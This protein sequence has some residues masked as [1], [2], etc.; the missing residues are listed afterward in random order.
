MD[1][2]VSLADVQAVAGIDIGSV[3]C[4]YTV[5]TCSKAV[6]R[7]PAEF[8]NTAAG[9]A[10]LAAQLAHLDLAPAQLLVGVEATSRYW[11]NL[12]YFLVG[13]GYAVQVLHPAQTHAFAQQR[14]LRAKTEAYYRH[15]V[16]TGVAK[17]SALMAVIRKMLLV[18]YGILKSGQRYDAR[19][20]WAA[21]QPPRAATTTEEA[22]AAA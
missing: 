4:S 20:V 6:L 16:E 17:M 8:A 10:A 21:P 9:F 22:P 3:T 7:K 11:E 14:G 18:A 5:L 19:K 15:L 1:R 13:Q 12:Y 2:P